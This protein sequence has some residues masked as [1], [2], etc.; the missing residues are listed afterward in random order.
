MSDY[1]PGIMAL[2]ELGIKSPLRYAEL[3]KNDIRAL[4][5][6]LGLPTWDK[7]SSACL[8]SRFVYGEEIT[9]PKLKMVEEGE[10]LLK[11]LGFKQLRVRIHGTSAR[12]EVM[13]EDFERI[14]EKNTR[15]KIYSELK[16]LGFSYVTLDLKGYRIGSMNETISE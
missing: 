13:P 14:I 3:T 1:R 12:I 9:K 6:E 16:K 7:P 8:A 15:E 4:S 11:N 10:E 2:D 5:H